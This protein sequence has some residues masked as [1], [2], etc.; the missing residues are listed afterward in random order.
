MQFLRQLEETYKEQLRNKMN[1]EM[2]KD[3]DFQLIHEK[4]NAIYAA[5]ISKS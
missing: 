5:L 1:F 3:E 4:V 2:K